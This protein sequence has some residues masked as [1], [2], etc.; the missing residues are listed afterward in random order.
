M[1]D[2]D[3]DYNYHN[4]DYDYDYIRLRLRLHTTTT[5]T[6]YDY[7]YNNNYV[8]LH[9][10]DYDYDYVRLQLPQQYLETG[11]PPQS[12]L[13]GTQNKKPRTEQTIVQNKKLL[14]LHTCTTQMKIV[15]LKLSPIPPGFGMFGSPIPSR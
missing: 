13:S 5:T 4:Y 9:I 12:G 7:D 3:Y 11:P 8:R 2:Y 14:R 1:Y 10:H 15:N 6:T